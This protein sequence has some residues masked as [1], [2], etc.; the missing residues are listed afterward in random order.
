[1]QVTLFRRRAAPGDDNV[2]RRPAARRR[3]GWRPWR[4]S[5]ASGDD[6]TDRSTGRAER[7][8]RIEVRQSPFAG[9]PNHH[10]FPHASLTPP[11]RSPSGATAGG[12]TLIAP[13]SR[14]R[15]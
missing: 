15:R 8:R 9:V 5:A 2:W 6:G 4:S 11:R 3:A 12:R 1:M 7:P 10:W 14:A 13:A